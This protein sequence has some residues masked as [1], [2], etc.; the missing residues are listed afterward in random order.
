MQF[1]ETRNETS[2]TRASSPRKK[3]AKKQ[4]HTH[5]KITLFVVMIMVTQ[6][7]LG[8]LSWHRNLR[9]LRCACFEKTVKT[10]RSNLLSVQ[11]KMENKTQLKVS[12]FLEKPS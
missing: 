5:K 2:E 6:Q 9:N 1:K 7:T 10:K 3:I 8:R 4:K 12:A 11:M